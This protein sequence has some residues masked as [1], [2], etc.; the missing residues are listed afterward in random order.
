MQLTRTGWILVGLCVLAGFSCGSDKASNPPV[1]PE[2]FNVEAES[3]TVSHNI[4]GDDIGLA[5]CSGAS[6]RYVV[7]GLDMEGEW[8]DLALSVPQT[9]LYDVTI[10]YQALADSVIVVKITSGDCGGEQEPA[11]TLNQGN[12][13]G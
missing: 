10:R 5:F 13:V 2:A 1:H 4:G 6:G 3:Y 9:G 12:G 11:F 7:T 8:I